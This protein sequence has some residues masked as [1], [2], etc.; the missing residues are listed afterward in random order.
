M[1]KI[2]I[3]AVIVLLAVILAYAATKPDAFRVERS[4][5]IKAAPE[6]IFALINDFHHWTS[7]SPY[8]KLDPAMKRT[9][10][11]AA[12]GQGAGYAWESRGKAGVGRMEIMAASPAKI[13]IRL[14]FIKPFEATH[15]AEFILE[16][17]GDAT[18]LTWAMYGR[19]PYIAKIMCLFFNR[20]RMIGDD[21]EIGLAN[22]KALAEK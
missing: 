11:G 18:R 3:I 19:D 13:S 16:P 6:K 8:E 12:S 1:L 20:D 15:T 10:S 7:W 9:Y 17:Q 21:F 4:I 14:Q 5:S 22:L 2:I